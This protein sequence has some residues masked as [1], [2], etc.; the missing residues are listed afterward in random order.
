V[1]T[2]S[3]SIR[4]AVKYSSNEN[5]WSFFSVFSTDVWVL[6]IATALIVGLCAWI[7]ETPKKEA[8]I[9]AFSI[10]NLREMLWQSYSTLFFN[11]TIEI[12][13]APTRIVFL[14]F[15]FLVLLMAATYQAQ[16]T[17]RLSSKNVNSKKT[18]KFKYN[19]KIKNQYEKFIPIKFPLNPW[20]PLSSTRIWCS[21]P[22]R[23]MTGLI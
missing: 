8:D 11:N 9:Q 10:F 5:I 16:Q 2:V 21:T 23:A 7:F 12:S 1:P 20:L 6:F 13:R 17:V 18:K 3:S 14:G 19:P 15:W 22:I 4:M